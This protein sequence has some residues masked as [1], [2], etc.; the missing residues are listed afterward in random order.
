[1]TP[2]TVSNDGNASRT[3]ATDPMTVSSDLPYLEA[4]R[5]FQTRR[6]GNVIVWTRK[7]E[8]QLK[9]LAALGLDAAII[10]AE[11]GLHERT[12]RARLKMLGLIKRNGWEIW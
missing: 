1:M 12:V 5:R 2:L 7:R 6:N 4:A 8:E 3:R 9:E 10:A 11:L